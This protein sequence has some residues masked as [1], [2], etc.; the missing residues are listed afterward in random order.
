MDYINVFRYLAS[1]YPQGVN[2]MDNRGHGLLHAA[3]EEGDIRIVR[4][5]IETH[6]LDPLA[7]DKD[8]ITCLHLIKTVYIYQYLKPNIQSN[9][10]PKDKSGRTPLH[11][12][13]RSGN[14]RMVHYLIET[15]PCTP[16]DPDNN[17]YTSV[18]AACEAGSLEL[19]QYFLTELKCNA[20]AE[21]D[22][23]KTMLYFASMSSNLELVRFLVDVFSLKP[24]PYDIDIAQAVN[25]DSSVVKYLQ[26]I[27]Y[28]LF[29]LEQSK[30][31][32][33]NET[34]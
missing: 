21:T 22:D 11:Y 19:V 8:G 13:S 23:L 3:C 27:H 24:R 1:I 10:T 7:E 34:D 31:G 9:P 29:L 14:I 16:D 32:G 12:A 20:L 28:D 15:F 25:P 5:L 18:H 26:E 33:Y 17:G 4:T 2:V 30:V 6:G